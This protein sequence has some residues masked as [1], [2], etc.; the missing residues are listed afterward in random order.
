M[1]PVNI[2]P[3]VVLRMAFGLLMFASMVRFMAQGWVTELYVLPQFH[4]SYAGFELDTAVTPHRPLVSSS[5]F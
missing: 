4:F 1:L 5:S 2:G 3:L